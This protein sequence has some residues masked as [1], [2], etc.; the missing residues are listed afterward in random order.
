MEL[1]LR[2]FEPTVN[3]QSDCARNVRPSVPVEAG[4]I[5][6]S[7]LRIVLPFPKPV[8]LGQQFRA[9]VAF[10][11]RHASLLPLSGV[12]TASLGRFSDPAHGVGT[13]RRF[14]TDGWE[15]GAIKAGI[16]DAFRTLRSEPSELP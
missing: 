15:R 2:V 12:S 6:D 13:W 1:V 14:L 10:S 11:S 3:G 5:D 7:Q 4:T 16:V 8:R 9:C